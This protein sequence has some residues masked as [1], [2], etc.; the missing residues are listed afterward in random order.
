MVARADN[1]TIYTNAISSW[2]DV[3]DWTLSSTSYNATNDGSL[4]FSSGT[5][6]IMPE[7]NVDAGVVPTVQITAI[8]GSS[9]SLYTSSDGSSYAYQGN[10]T[11]GGSSTT[12]TRECPPGTRF[13]KFD[14]GA[15]SVYLQSLTITIPIAVT[16][17]TLNKATTALAVGGSTE[18]LTATV[19][20]NNAADQSVAWSSSDDGV[21]TVNN[22]EIAAV[23]EG[24]ATITVTTTDGSKTATCDVTVSATSVALTGVALNKTTTRLFA[25]RSTE[26]LT[27][28]F[29]PA[30]ATNQNVSWGSSA[31]SIAIV[32]NGVVT[33]VAVGDAIITV[34]AADGGHQATCA[35]T[36]EEPPLDTV[37]VVWA[38]GAKNFSYTVNGNI[39]VDWG[40]GSPVETFSSGTAYP[41]PYA[42]VYNTQGAYTATISGDNLT[43]LDL[44]DNSVLA[45]DLSKAH[46]LTS[47]KC[48]N[49]LITD[50]NL[51][52]NTNGSLT[53]DVGDN[54]LSAAALNA[55][56]TQFAPASGITRQTFTS[57]ATVGTP[58][59]LKGGSNSYGT[60]IINDGSAT[61]G[62][63]SA[64]A[65]DYT[66]YNDD[67]TFNTEGAYLV[68]VG[69]IGSGG[70]HTVNN[71]VTVVSGYA[72]DQQQIDITLDTKGSADSTVFS[73]S[74]SYGQPFDVNWGD[75]TTETYTGE[76]ALLTLVHKYTTA[77]SKS[78]SITA[79]FTTLLTGL[80]AN[81]N[82]GHSVFTALDVTKAPALERLLCEN[83]KLTTLDVRNNLWLGRLDCGYNH[84]LTTLQL[85]T[86]TNGVA[87]YSSASIQVECQN[88]RIDTVEIGTRHIID[89]SN[90]AISLQGAYN[91]KQTATSSTI[92]DQ[93][94]WLSGEATVLIP[95]V[96]PAT[97]GSSVAT[98]VTVKNSA[99]STIT[100]G[101]TY[102]P[103][104]GITFDANGYYT[105]ELTN[106]AIIT[107]SGTTKVIYNFNV[108]M[109]VQSITFDW[110]AATTA[111]TFTLA[112][113]NN[114]DFTVDWGDS[115]TETYTGK[116]TGTSLTLSH[117]YAAEGDYTVNIA[118]VDG[119]CAFYTLDLS[120]TELT[121]LTTLS[122]P[123][124]TT[125]DVS[126]NRLTLSQ[127]KDIEAIRGSATFTYGV[128]TLPQM[129]TTDINIP[130]AIDG[131]YINSTVSVRKKR[132]AGWNVAAPG[133]YTWAP[134]SNE[135]TF[136]E[137]GW[138]YEVALQN[139][140]LPG[141]QV[142]Q[143]FEVGTI[144]SPSLKVTFRITDPTVQKPKLLI[145]IPAGKSITVDYG[146]GRPTATFTD[147][148]ANTYDITNN[149]SYT[150][151]GTYTITCTTTDMNDH[152]TKV[153]IQDCKAKGITVDGSTEP[154]LAELTIQNTDADTLSFVDCTN[155][156]H[157]ECTNN[158][159]LVEVN[160]FAASTDFL[161]SGD[162]K[163]GGSM[164]SMQTQLDLT[165]FTNSYPYTHLIVAPQTMPT[166]RVSTGV[167]QVIDNRA[168]PTT[169]DVIKPLENSAAAALSTDYTYSSGSIT[170]NQPGVYSVII[171]QQSA[172]T[173]YVA[174]GS[175]YTFVV[176]GAP[177]TVP[178][179]PVPF[180]EDTFDP[181][182]WVAA[183]YSNANAWA[184]SPTGGK[185]GG[186]GA[187]LD[188]NNGYPSYLFFDVE[189]PTVGSN[190]NF[191][192]TFDY[193]N[194][195]DGPSCWLDDTSRVRVPYIYAN[196]E[197]NFGDIAA[198]YYGT[199]SNWSTATI[200][201]PAAQYAGT[202]K[203]LGFS[204]R[205][206]GLVAIDNVSIT[207]Y[208]SYTVTFNTQGGTARSPINVE[209]G[210]TITAPAAPT[211]VGSIFLG[212]YK[213][214]GLTN[215]WDFATDVVTA[216]ITLYAKWLVPVTGVTLNKSTTSLVIGAQETL[217]ATVE[218]NN[219]TNQGV[220]WVS[221]DDGKASVDGTGKVT[222]VAVGTAT[223][224]VTT[225]YGSYT[226]TCNVT[227]SATSVAVT[228][229]SLDKVA[230]SLVI[231]GTETLTP[232][233]APNN[234]TNQNVSWSSNNTGVAEVDGTG[235]VTAKAV[236]T[237][238]ITVTTADGS[239]T[240]TCTVTV[241]ATSV[242]VT[243]DAQGGS[244]VAPQVIAEGGKATQPAN[245]TL[246]G[247]TFAGWYKEASYAAAWNFVTDAVTA[248]ITLYAKWIDATVPTHTV[249]F[250]AQGGSTIA[251]QTIAQGEKVTQPANP[252]KAGY[253]FG[254][255]YKEASCTTAWNFASDVVTANVTLYAKW[256]EESVTTYT[257]T[258]NVQGG[259]AVASQTI[260]QG[261]KVN[262][263]ANPTK[264]GYTFGGWYKEATC[265]NAW[266]FASNVVT[267]NVT[268]Y[269]KWTQDSGTDPTDPSTAVAEEV[270]SKLH[271]YP[272]PVS[273]QLTITSDQWNAG[274]KVEIY[275]VNGV[276]VGA[277]RIRPDGEMRVSQKGVFNTP[278]QGNTITINIAHLPAGIYIVKVGNKVAKVVKQ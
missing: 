136:I 86:A 115:N 80:N 48:Y 125:L 236:G 46:S 111:K 247:F 59:T 252:T 258:F 79:P 253:T 172:S 276:L 140:A 104:T 60:I 145:D 277:Y 53:V 99:G 97:L 137:D 152:F 195:S 28:I 266:N 262:Q 39:T 85:S 153:I 178:K 182:Q 34:T 25:G 30:N 35:V 271:I 71:Y 242:T 163:F 246:A 214:A 8:Q 87:K 98:V 21:A 133:D 230:T 9:I 191:R 234:A 38:S 130:H 128:Q 6:A 76:T 36:V 120:N 181:A 127:L 129:V 72:A 2:D 209:S 31:P 139:D 275:N 54:Y 256:T 147:N 118:A 12:S 132:L 66:I 96:E 213:E 22:G 68:V 19:V 166:Q 92:G 105:V 199:G 255:W 20:P 260:A 24:T 64:A 235:K 102:T 174:I 109:G 243:F 177:L 223:I 215:A 18:T 227:V 143:T 95:L 32:S 257:V 123:T 117:T 217:T 13:I 11:G 33:P 51:I 212:W 84:R 65:S 245:P 14:A 254:G 278:L 58:V 40:D 210:S 44:D 228:S 185:D 57:I 4:W 183:N 101:F 196:N 197:H 190:T 114:R 78:V 194:T 26:T 158:P 7:L 270:A 110:A 108:G 73:L 70:S 265:T 5:S 1:T 220:T 168:S 189:F 126:N 211:K 88:N 272:N 49:N 268:L 208:D 10:F 267:A 135:I 112:E 175:T 103:G 52:L 207:E 89:C 154:Q 15:N 225:D 63:A 273:D 169:P 180:T 249:T 203:R 69:S 231:G 201:L 221:S 198:I 23:A 61:L 224:T 47:L 77:G 187:T 148:G 56:G 192:L 170:F 218:P 200:D 83:H 41:D 94:R 162:V 50:G 107:S 27:P 3:A 138:Q 233:I 16:R 141:A 29:T 159:S 142:K 119:S 193:N 91:I 239:K 248:N 42:S 75:G 205:R 264:A 263:P 202:V 216:N 17:V 67:I 161:S 173:N 74:A 131:T 167:A 229:V 93:N 100:T 232:T 144:P 171:R 116:G 62:T 176:D 186:A 240:A 274:N 157:L 206:G 269:A 219:A 259:S 122:T 121:S 106:A 238:T 151:A 241:S 55:L 226:A 150:A 222:A 237:A 146:D 251:A 113:A 149:I 244:A 156:T 160:G 90:N 250:D 43:M 261:E 165:T 179:Q 81:H 37:R 124:L 134:A 45:V 188:G 164:M 184:Y 155:L 82:D 204:N